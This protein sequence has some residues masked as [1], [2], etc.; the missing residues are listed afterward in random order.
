MTPE[1]ATWLMHYD[2]WSSSRKQLDEKRW[3][4]VINDTILPDIA[5]RENKFKTRDGF[6]RTNRQVH[7]LHQLTIQFGVPFPKEALQEALFL[8]IAPNVG[9]K[10]NL[11]MTENID[12]LYTLLIKNL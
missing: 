7:F 8:N 1:T 9:K 12:E 10:K 2:T 4:E 11:T 5:K 6:L 3:S